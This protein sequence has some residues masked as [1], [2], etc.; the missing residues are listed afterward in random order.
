MFYSVYHFQSLFVFHHIYIYIYILKS[1]LPDLRYIKCINLKEY[2]GKI[3]VQ[4]EESDNKET[5][6]LFDYEN[7]GW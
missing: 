3:R 5:C 7:R 4:G 2:I 6:S 1:T